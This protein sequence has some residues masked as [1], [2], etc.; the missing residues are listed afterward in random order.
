[1]FN[2]RCIVQYLS[3]NL[4]KKCSFEYFI[5]SKFIKYV[6]DSIS[7]FNLLR[8]DVAGAEVSFAQAQR[9]FNYN[10][11]SVFIKVNLNVWQTCH[12]L[13]QIPG[14]LVW[15]RSHHIQYLN[16]FLWVVAEP[17]L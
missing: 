9:L 11:I 5:S 13:F 3:L 7:C 4:G 6:Q 17:E 14:V 8:Y 15:F 2:D 16:T 10:A 12:D 1:M